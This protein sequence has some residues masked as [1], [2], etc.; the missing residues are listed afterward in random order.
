MTFKHQYKFTH[1]RNTFSFFTIININRQICNAIQRLYS[2]LT[3][4][5]IYFLV[6]F[7]QNPQPSTNQS[8]ELL[9]KMK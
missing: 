3:M 1:F 7:N 5:I 4:V 2:H 8:F 9:L 6:K